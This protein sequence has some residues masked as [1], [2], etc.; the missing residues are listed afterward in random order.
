LDLSADPLNLAGRRW[1]LHIVVCCPHFERSFDLLR[2]KHLRKGIWRAGKNV[3]RGKRTALG[4]NAEG[5]FPVIVYFCECWCAAL[6]IRS[7][8]WLCD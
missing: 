7:A 2:A 3:L 4:A 8:S 6:V 5:F 1:T